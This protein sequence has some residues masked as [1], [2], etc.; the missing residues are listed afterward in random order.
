MDG[1]HQQ[2][3]SQPAVYVDDNDM[4]QRE[5]LLRSLKQ[6]PHILRDFYQFS[7][8]TR[9]RSAQP[10]VQQMCYGQSIQDQ[11]PIPSI[12]NVK[13]NIQHNSSTPKRGRSLNDSGGSISSAPKQ[14]KSSKGTRMQREDT[15]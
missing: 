2:L 9:A 15:A 11:Q 13:T 5:G 6:N 7:E 4:E 12:L 3:Y 10:S 1:R 8:F 14:Q